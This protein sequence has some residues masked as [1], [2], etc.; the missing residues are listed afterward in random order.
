MQP[1]EHR[2][3]ALGGGGGDPARK[4]RSGRW[5]PSTAT[6][7]SRRCPPTSRRHPHQPPGGAHQPPGGTRTSL[8]GC[9]CRH[10]TG[11][12]T[13]LSPAALTRTAQAPSSRRKRPCSLPPAD[14]EEQDGTL[15]KCKSSELGPRARKG[16]EQK[17]ERWRSSSG[18]GAHFTGG[19][20]IR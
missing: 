1:V 10:V 16:Q 2:P 5:A 6:P 18:E 4:P 12:G 17:M 11:A 20:S 9:T 19:V 13:V 3:A 7:A 15:E 8:P 14:V